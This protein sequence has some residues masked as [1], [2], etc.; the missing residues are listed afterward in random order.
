MSDVTFDKRKTFLKL[1]FVLIISFVWVCYM[2]KLFVDEKNKLFFRKKIRM[3][4]EY[5]YSLLRLTIAKRNL[6]T[7]SFTGSYNILRN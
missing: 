6:L 4:F 1:H 7:C 2:D 3:L 5:E